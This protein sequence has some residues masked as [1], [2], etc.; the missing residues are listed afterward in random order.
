L[1]KPTVTG[2]MKKYYIY[3]MPVM[4]L[5]LIVLAG[6]RDLPQELR[7]TVEKQKADRVKTEITFP[8][9]NL[10][11]SA[12][13]KSFCE[14]IYKYRHDFWKPEISYYEESGTGYLDIEFEDDRDRRD[15]DD[16]DENEWIIAFDRDTRND[17]KLE[18]IAGESNIDLE[19]CKLDGFEFVMVAGES[20]INL[21]NTSVPFLEF[22]A[23]A[24]EA[25]IDLSGD[26]NNDLDAEI[27]GGVGDLK[28][29]VPSKVG[30]K[31]NIT[32]GLGDV[33]AHGLHKENRNY[34]NNLYGKTRHSLYIDVT[35][36]IGNV[37]IRM[38][39]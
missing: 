22:K 36:G 30:V 7:R 17:I 16:S 3:F 39:D 20:K 11:I 38:V 10:Y 34:T 19:G 18:M 37:D 27:K 8:A 28:I 4:A 6:F 33:D 2:R 14:G 15:Y 31:I 1:R 26:W 21:R 35:G 9:G 25:E 32:G 5:F 12:N 24:G 29:L 13:A 23:V